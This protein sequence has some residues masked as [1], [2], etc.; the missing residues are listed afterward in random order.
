MPRSIKRSM[1]PRNAANLVFS[2]LGLRGGANRRR[3]WPGL[4]ISGISWLLDSDGTDTVINAIDGRAGVAEDARKVVTRQLTHRS[5]SP[6]SRLRIS[7]GSKH[8][9][10]KRSGRGDGDQSVLAKHEFT[11]GEDVPATSNVFG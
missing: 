3:N 5:T 2:T 1:D 4:E 8:G 9:D 6:C 10:A 7:R 11:F